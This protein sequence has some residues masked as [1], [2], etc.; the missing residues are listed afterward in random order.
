[1]LYSSLKSTPILCLDGRAHCKGELTL[2]QARLQLG[3]PPLGFVNPLL[4]GRAADAFVDVR[5]GTN[6]I[7][8]D[9]Q[10]LKFGFNCTRGW[11]PATGLGTPRFD[12][13]AAPPPYS[14]PFFKGLTSSPQLGTCGRIRRIAPPCTLQKSDRCPRLVWRCDRRVY[15]RSTGPLHCKVARGGTGPSC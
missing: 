8:R 9:G 6:A 10:S 3:Q 5:A 15:C 2:R 14:Q 12:R 13:S 11:D 4:Y 7:G 1:M